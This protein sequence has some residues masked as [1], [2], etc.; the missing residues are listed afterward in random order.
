MNYTENDY[1]N[2]LCT[3]EQ[4]TEETQIKVLRKDLVFLI[5]KGIKDVTVT[6]TEARKEFKKLVKE[7]R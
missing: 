5:S 2:E 6:D 3:F 1:D 7:N 4:L